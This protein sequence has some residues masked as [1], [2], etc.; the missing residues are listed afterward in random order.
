MRLLPNDLQTYMEA[1]GIRA[2]LIRNI[3]D[4]PTVPAAAL[5]LGVETDQIIKTLLFLVEREG[6]AERPRE[7]IV[8]GNGESRV[9]T[10]ALAEHLGVGR[11]RVKLASPE[12]VLDL[13]G[14]PA[15]GVPPFGHRTTM[16]VIIDAAIVALEERFG[17]IIYG[18]G[19]D[20]HT[21][22]ELSVAELVRVTQAQIL[23]VS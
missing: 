21:M 14:Y 18:G 2:R 20:A 7:I 10:R 6:N 11:K 4:T 15:G 3:G 1:H 8:I 16:P 5:A 9:D 13:L 23:A 19:G 17:G 12:V 22:L